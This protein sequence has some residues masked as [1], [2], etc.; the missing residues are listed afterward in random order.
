[1]ASLQQNILQA[2][3]DFDGIKQ[4]IIDNGVDVPYGTDTKEYGELVR[5]ACK[6]AFAKIP[7]WEKFFYGGKNLSV[8]WDCDF[9]GAT[10]CKQLCT[11]C[12]EITDLPVINSHNATIHTSA[13]AYCEK[14]KKATVDCSSSTDMSSM[15]AGCSDITEINLVNTGKSTNLTSTFTNCSSLRTITGLDFSS[16]GGN[17]SAFY[18]T[19]SLENCVI[20]GKLTLTKS[21]TCNYSDNLTVETLMSF[22]NAFE[23]PHLEAG[24]SYPAYFGSTN[25]DRLTPEQIAIATAKNIKLA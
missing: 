21:F 5:K 24:N 9:S 12:K 7:N 11:N 6:K 16:V 18:N 8:M 4:A 19:S 25:L 10:T 23:N 3:S 17:H 14:L 15:F 13:F 20:T 1:M 22:I 2:I